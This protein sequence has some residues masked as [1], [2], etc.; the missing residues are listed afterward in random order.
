MKY[1]LRIKFDDLVDEVI[2]RVLGQ[3]DTQTLK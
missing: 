3:I 1:F 2:D